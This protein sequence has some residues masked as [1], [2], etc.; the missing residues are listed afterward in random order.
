MSSDWCNMVKLYDVGVFV[1]MV[2]DMML[3]GEY[4][5]MLYFEN[6][7]VVY[8]IDLMFVLLQFGYIYWIGFDY[9]V[10][11]S[12]VYC[13]FIGMDVVVG[14]KVILI[15]FSCI[16][17][18]QVLQMMEFFQDVI[19]GCGDYI[20]VG[21]EWVG[22]LDVDFVFDDFM[23]IDFGEMLGGM[24]CVMVFGEVVVFSFGMQIVFIMI[25]INSELIVV[26][27]IGVQFEVFEGYVVEVVDDLLNL[28]DEVVVGD[29]VEIIWLVMVFV[30]VV[31][32]MVGIGIVV[33][34]FVDC[35][36]CMVGMMQEVLVFLWVCIFN[37]QIIV[38]VSLEE[39]LG[40]DGVV[41]NMF[42]GNVGMFWYSWWSLVVILYLYV[43]MFDFGVV[44]QVDGILYLC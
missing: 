3:D 39:I 6:S 14:G 13:W 26:D 8:C 11:V 1:G 41:V 38:M 27:N 17:F 4:L 7:G 34:Y 29:S 40:E 36:V 9:Q 21:F 15:M 23:V 18:M 19:V 28:F 31:G 44:E 5:L 25:F 16:G 20:W 30:D 24:F 2:V 35:D 42:D 12:G 43:L 33:M 10:G 22:G 32:M 37:V